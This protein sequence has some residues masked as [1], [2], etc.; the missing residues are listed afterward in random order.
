MPAVDLADLRRYAVA[1]SLFAPTTLAAAIRRL[2]FVQAD[3]IRA[4]ARAQDLLL[5]HRVA[6]YSAGDLERRYPRLPIEEDFFVN[7]GFVPRAT[8]HLMHP[9]TAR[10]A[11]PAA[12]AAQ[13][14][15]V[16]D[17]VRE[18]G[19]VHPREVDLHFAHGKARNWFGGS[20]NASTQLLDAM[21]YRGLLRIERR[22]GGVRLYAVRIAPED[23][24]G[25]PDVAFDALIDI[26]VRLYA[27]LPA[28]GLAQLVSYLRGGAPQWAHLRAAAL[29]RACAR[30]ASA[31]VD[32]SVWYWPADENLAS[33]R[34]RIEDTVRVLAPFDPVVW[35]RARFERLWGWP[36]R[37][38]A[39]TPAAK[40]VRGYY[41]LPLLWRDR[42]IG[43]GNLAVEGGALRADFGYAAGRAPRDGL[44]RN[45]LDAEL[46]RMREFLDCA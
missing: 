43:W 23:G 44:F 45:E 20:G 34:H 4:P 19:V 3:P 18:R 31:S 32:G 7:Y 11:W 15:S 41:A 9:R 26:V 28:R 30:L 37:F 1:R 6:G 25:D 5:R 29:A 33:K 12:R 38:E 17:F 36:Y 27:P 40:R 35:D 14:Q 10:A 24:A 2:G 46:Q 8:H 21:H 13:A 39:Y 42:V 16:L 22:V